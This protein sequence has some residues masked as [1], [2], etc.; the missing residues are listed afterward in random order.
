MVKKILTKKIDIPKIN[1]KVEEVKV[2]QAKEEVKEYI[3]KK[4]VNQSMK[5]GTKVDKA[6]YDKLCANGLGGWF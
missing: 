2:V 1:I 6:T 3:L 5:A 4:D